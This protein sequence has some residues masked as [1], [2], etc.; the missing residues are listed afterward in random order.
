M[1][2]TDRALHAFLQ[3]TDGNLPW[4][5]ADRCLTLQMLGSLAPKLSARHRLHE[6][7]SRC[8][9]LLHQVPTGF[10]PELGVDEAMSRLDAL[11]LQALHGMP[12]PHWS[13][14]ELQAYIERLSKTSE[15][16]LPG[17]LM[18]EQAVI[19]EVKAQTQFAERFPF[20]KTDW[21]LHLYHL[22][23]IVLVDTDYFYREAQPDRYSEE[24]QHFTQAVDLT[25]Q[26]G[27][28]DILGE[29]EFCRAACGQK[30]ERALAGLR[31]AQLAD[32]SWA[33]VPGSPRHEAHAT[34]ACLLA[35]AA[36]DELITNGDL[37]TVPK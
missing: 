17:W 33:E 21:G 32:G 16:R 1:N 9:N 6:K 19:L 4:Q 14:R 23:H 34:A 29:I 20:L 37:S 30:N 18:G 2:S 28:W 27:M 25:I 15:G 24:L 8:L 12:L 36:S 22:T 26:H 13:D 7:L 5:L 35:L 11:Y 10:A 3:R 31:A